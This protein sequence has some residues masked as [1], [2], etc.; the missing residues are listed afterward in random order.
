MEERHVRRGE[1]TRTRLVQAALIIMVGKFWWWRRR[2][3]RCAD[4]WRSADIHRW[5]CRYLERHHLA[6]LSRVLVPFGV[7]HS[8]SSPSSPEVT[9]QNNSSY[10][11][12]Y[13]F[14]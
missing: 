3:Q 10:D 8:A 14:H 11:V 5:P 13:I 4:V 7:L 2:R 6:G 9:Q 12:G 1:R